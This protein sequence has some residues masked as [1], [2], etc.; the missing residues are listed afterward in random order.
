VIPVMFTIVDDIWQAIKR[1]LMPKS[2]HAPA[3]GE[4]LFAQPTST[5][6]DAE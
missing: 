6:A 1:R 5:G 4:G 3:P 2:V